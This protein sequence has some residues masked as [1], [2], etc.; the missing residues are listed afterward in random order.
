VGV[1]TAAN[2]LFDEN[3]F[4]WRWFALSAYQSQQRLSHTFWEGILHGERPIS[5]RL[6]RP[7]FAA[8]SLSSTY[9]KGRYSLVREFGYLVSLNGKIGSGKLWSEMILPDLQRR[10]ETTRLVLF[11]TRKIR[12]EQ[13][14]RPPATI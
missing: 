9:G 4:A 5:L 8:H 14:H 10:F 7:I 13:A 11:L 6:K 12:S 3:P 2:E 1:E